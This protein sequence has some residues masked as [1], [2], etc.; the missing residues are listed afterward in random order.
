MI[1]EGENESSSEMSGNNGGSGGISREV[2]SGIFRAFLKVSGNEKKVTPKVFLAV[3]KVCCS[4]ALSNGVS[5]HE[6]EEKGRGGGG[7]LQGSP[8]DGGIMNLSGIDK[9]DNGN[10]GGNFMY[11]AHQRG[12][13]VNDANMA[14]AVAA[15][16]KEKGKIATPLPTPKYPFTVVNFCRAS[17]RFVGLQKILE[18]KSKEI[19]EELAH[20]Y[21]PALCSNSLRLDTKQ[22]EMLANSKGGAGELNFNDRLARMELKKKMVV[23]KVADKRSDLQKKELEECTFSPKIIKVKKKKKK[24]KKKEEGGGG[25][26]GENRKR[27]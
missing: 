26:G 21:E 27:I 23:K 10:E 22:M 18:Q 25:G 3:A 5:V 20:P 1:E 19:E 14:K 16:K 13:V 17:I 15:Y 9:V 24:K 2:S 7:G 12:S 4:S 11:P 6:F 8:G